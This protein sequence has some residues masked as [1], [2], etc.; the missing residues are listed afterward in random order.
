MAVIFDSWLG[1]E[2]R[3]EKLFRGKN[4]ERFPLFRGRKCSF[5]G[6]PSSIEEPIPKLGT[7]GNGPEFREKKKFYRIV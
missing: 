7:E 5:R 4:S 6:I 2:F 3:S 1:R